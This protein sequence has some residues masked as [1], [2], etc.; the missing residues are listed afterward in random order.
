MNNDALRAAIMAVATS[1]VSTAVLLGLVGWDTNQVAGVN[2][3][4]GNAVL[5]LALV[6]KKGE[7]APAPAV[8]DAYVTKWLGIQRAEHPE[9]CWMRTDQTLCLL[10]RGHDDGVHG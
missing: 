2:L 10:D 9:I 8:L 6:F 5:L 4:V 1:A 3:F 7:A